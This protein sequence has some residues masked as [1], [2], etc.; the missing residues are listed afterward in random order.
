MMAICFKASGNIFP[1]LPY[2]QGRFSNG[3]VWV[4]QLAPLLG[5]QPNSNT[6]FAF[7]GATTGTDNNLNYLFPTPLPGL[8]QEINSF[9]A[10]LKA[11]NKSADANALYIVWAGADDYLPTPGSFKPF[12]Q[13]NIPV[14]NLS[15][16][17]TSLAGVGAKNIM[18]V[19][20]PDLGEAPLTV[21]S[22]LSEQLDT[23]TKAHNSALA[24]TLNGLS[25]T[26][27]P[28][29]NIIPFDVNSIFSNDRKSPEKFGITNLTAPCFNK[30][31]SAVCANPN[32]YAFWDN[33]HPTTTVDTVIAESAYEVLCVPEPCDGLATSAFAACGVF[34][35]LK[36]KQRGAQQYGEI[37][38]HRTP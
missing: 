18:V 26:L 13:P 6:N 21:G 8:Q 16:A 2:Y 36:R 14:K 7:S 33:V 12:G 32:Q 3:P 9:T 28:A 25:Q 4:E 15:N 5:L 29:V 27:G 31:T 37:R 35:V 17:V 19:N 1:P 22:P 11:A 30:T 24:A 23:L 20:L 34:L 10:P 38:G